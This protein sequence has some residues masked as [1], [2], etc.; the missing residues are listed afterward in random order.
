MK[1]IISL[2]NT[3]YSIFSYMMWYHGYITEVIFPYVIA[4]GITFRCRKEQ[5]IIKII[6]MI[7]I[8]KLF[9]KNEK[10]LETDTKKL[11]YTT[12]NV[13]FL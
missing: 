6:I 11:E 3:H 8:I 9:A 4:E 5:T 2:K 13:P 1:L 10:E 7:I 12:E